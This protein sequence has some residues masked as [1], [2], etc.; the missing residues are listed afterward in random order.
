MVLKDKTSGSQSQ[1]TFR[2]YN[3]SKEPLTIDIEAYNLSV[4]SNGQEKVRNK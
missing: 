4:D 2:V 3:G 1:Q